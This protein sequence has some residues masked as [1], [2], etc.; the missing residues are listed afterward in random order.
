MN[1]RKVKTV[2]REI[3]QKQRLNIGKIEREKYI[4]VLNNF[5]YPTNVLMIIY[6]E[7]IYLNY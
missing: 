3:Y 6:F 4:F 2:K 7:K 1:D 5:S